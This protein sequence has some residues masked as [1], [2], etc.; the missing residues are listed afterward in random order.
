[1]F[2][3]EGFDLGRIGIYFKT[4]FLFAFYS[5]KTWGSFRIAA[6]GEIDRLAEF[7]RMSSGQADEGNVLRRCGPDG[8]LGE[9]LA[10][11]NGTVNFD[12]QEYSYGEELTPLTELDVKMI[13]LFA[14]NR[15]RIISREELLERVWGMAGDEVETRKVDMQIV[16]LR[17][18]LEAAGRA[19]DLIKT[20]RGAG[21]IYAG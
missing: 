19:D 17:K 10:F 13:R 8:N 14:C 7:G 3:D 9:E 1:M 12:R 21:Y 20:V 16:K 11:G 18:K 15:D 5:L 6:D 4:S 2:C